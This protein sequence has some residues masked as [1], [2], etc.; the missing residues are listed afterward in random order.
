MGVMAVIVEICIWMT[1]NT[2]IGFEYD[3]R[4]I[5][6]V[7]KGTWSGCLGRFFDSGTD[8]ESFDSITYH[9]RHDLTT[10]KKSMAVWDVGK[11]S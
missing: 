5:P 3:S 8:L 9:S 2:M 11:I 6:Y 7:K 10:Y 1:R 4:I